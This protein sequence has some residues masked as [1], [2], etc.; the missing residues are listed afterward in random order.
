ML[1]KQENYYKWEA[2]LAKSLEIKYELDLEIFRDAY[3]LKAAHQQGKPIGLAAREILH[4][5]ER[6]YA[7]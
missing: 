1:I 5:L 6:R 4:I 7:I 2:T 3:D